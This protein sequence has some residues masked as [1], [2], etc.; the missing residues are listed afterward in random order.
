MKQKH[1]T[2]P[3]IN[4]LPKDP[5]YDTAVG[6][7]AL[8][9]I[10]IGRYI[11]IFTEIIVIM[12]F[13]TRFKLD[14]DLTNLNTSI[15]Q[16]NAIIESFGDVETR[17]RALQKQIEIVKKVLQNTNAIKAIDTVATYVPNGIEFSRFSFDSTALAIEGK[18]S[19][20]N[21]FASM[22]LSLQSEK[23]L[24]R[25]VSIEK[26]NSGEGNDPTVLFSISIGLTEKT[27]DLPGQQELKSF[28]E[29]I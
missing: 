14:R 25:T 7:F 2:I 26:I 12:S 5:F 18:A 23:S 21:L 1:V 10:Q 3:K 17:S 28:Q 15:V 9:A 16:K 13:A 29:K 8:W 19:S 24:F 22:I 20:S 4:L 6:K 27:S 11:I